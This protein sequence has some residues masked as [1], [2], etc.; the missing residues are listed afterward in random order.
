MPPTRTQAERR[1]SSERRLLDAT[2]LVIA[3]R[4]TT[5]VSFADIAKVAGCSHGLPGYLFG[6][7]VDLLLALVEDVLTQLRAWLVDPVVARQRGLSATLGVLRTFL[8]T[9]AD[10][11]PHT[12]A[13][14]VMLGEAPGA[15]PDLRRALQEYQEGV[16]RLFRQLLTEGIAGGEIRA[17]VDPDAQAVVLLGLARGIG[18]QLVLDPDAVSLEAVTSEVMA[19]VARALAP[20]PGSPVPGDGSSATTA[21][22][23]APS[24]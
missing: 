1:A 18:Q 12:R 17:D 23:P 9:L 13:M 11:T 16:R 15:P 3:E 24:P 22:S 19:T 10:P 21:P 6:S 2:A 20:V 14:Y 5:S 8:G 7:K 4:G